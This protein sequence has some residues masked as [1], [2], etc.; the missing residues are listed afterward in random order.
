[1]TDLSV[2]PL[3]RGVIG[4]VLESGEP[5]WVPDIVPVPRPRARVR[6]DQDGRGKPLKLQDIFDA[7]AHAERV[8][9]RGR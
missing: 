6:R 2:I 9:A 5:A 1:M 8:R 7:L 4:A 3:G